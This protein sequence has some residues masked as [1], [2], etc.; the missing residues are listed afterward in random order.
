MNSQNGES[1][2]GPN[3][4]ADSQSFTSSAP[5]QTSGDY[6]SRRAQRRAERWARAGD[7]LE[8]AGERMER[9]GERLERRAG[10]RYG[11]FGGAVLVL[12]GV[13]FLLQN[14]GLASLDNWWALFILIP[15]FWS[16]AA[17]WD[18]YQ[19]ARRL[20]RRVGSSLAGALLLTV[21]SLVFLFGLDVGSLW[22]VLLIVAGVILLAAALLPE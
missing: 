22:P 20:T 3:P 6:R 16:Y 17:A 7:R 21:L 8:R 5:P 13:I 2:A 19:N 10:R 14:L 11:W 18:Q 1:T 12:L 4:P 15:A 9:A